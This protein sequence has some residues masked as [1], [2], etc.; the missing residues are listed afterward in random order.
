M[1]TDGNSTGG[2]L[3]AVTAA[4]PDGE[5]PAADGDRWVGAALGKYLILRRLG[6]G[7]MGVVYEAKDHVL[8]R[9]V[10]VKVLRDAIAAQPEAVRKFLREARAAARLNHPHVVPVYEAGEEKGFCFLVMELMEGGSAHDRIR[11]WGPFGWQEATRVLAD[12]CRGLMAVHAAGLI[13]RDIKPSNIMR[14]RDGLVKLADFG[15]ALTA[16]GPADSTTPDGQVVGT[17]LYMSPEQCRGEKID[18]RSDI[19][20]LGATYY[21]L[22]TGRP[23][24]EADS[25]MEIMVGHCSKPVPDPRELNPQVPDA[26]ADLVH[27]AMAKLP[28]DRPADAAALFF[29]FEALLGPGGSAPGDGT[30]DWSAGGV[31]TGPGSTINSTIAEP[32]RPIRPHRRTRAWLVVTC[33][34]AMLAAAFGIGRYA[35]RPKL[36]PPPPGDPPAFVAPPGGGPDEHPPGDPPARAAEFDAGGRVNSLAFDPRPA[37]ADDLSWATKKGALRVHQA[38]FRRDRYAGTTSRGGTLAPADQVAYAPDGSTWLAVFDGGVHFFETEHFTPLASGRFAAPQCGRVLAA[39][40]RPQ[41]DVLALA[42]ADNTLEKGGILVRWLRDKPQDVTRRTADGLVPTCLG[43]SADGEYLLQGKDGGL[44]QVWKVTIRTKP[45]SNDERELAVQG[46]GSFKIGNGLVT[47]VVGC[48]GSKFAAALGGSVVLVDAR[49]GE[50]VR[51]LHAG[52]E[53]VTALAASPATQRVAWATGGSVT[54]Y[55]LDAGRKLAEWKEHARPVR[56]L[57]FD[58]RGLKLASGDDEGKV[59]IWPVK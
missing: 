27:R 31:R 33:L 39:A 21:T 51:T 49:A 11:K 30:L 6:R 45:F 41:G 13:H 15:L 36:T 17:P 2:P 57:A 54:I 3:A 35:N 42:Y 9:A 38:L 59:F 52:D 19:Y 22:L 24:F 14:T 29:E 48:E 56:A 40:Y 18:L 46:A 1:S 16:P 23:P 5:L 47:S 58:A 20:A 34:L 12:A 37:N 50:K 7:G 8:Q 53:P 55:D 44:V 43:F 32:I 4:A 26:C 10:A 28:A 25:A